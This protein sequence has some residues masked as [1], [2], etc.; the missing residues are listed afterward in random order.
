VGCPDPNGRSV[1]HERALEFDQRDR[2][3]DYGRHD[4]FN[5]GPDLGGTAWIA[6]STMTTTAIRTNRY[7]PFPRS[8]QGKLDGEDDSKP[9]CGQISTEPTVTEQIIRYYGELGSSHRQRHRRQAPGQKPPSSRSVRPVGPLRSKIL[10]TPAEGASPNG[11]VAF[12]VSTQ[13]LVHIL[14]T[15]TIRYR[16]GGQSPCSGRGNQKARASCF[17]SARAIALRPAR[18]GQR[19]RGQQCR[20][21]IASTRHRRRSLRRTPCNG[22]GIPVGARGIVVNNASAAYVM[23]YI[24]RDVTV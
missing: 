14:N 20:G 15:T 3:G 13:A 18:C 21:Q 11:P 2:Y 7:R 6:I 10:P 9:G 16:P 12:N 4:H 24:S 17:G 8:D 23:N 19:R 22:A 5:I 1:C